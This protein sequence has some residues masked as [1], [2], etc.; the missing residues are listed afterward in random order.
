M[1]SWWSSPEPGALRRFL[2]EVLGPDD[3]IRSSSTSSA[4][5]ARPARPWWASNFRAPPT[6][7]R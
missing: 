2:D 7:P 5:T 4:T 1:T 6:W 3:D